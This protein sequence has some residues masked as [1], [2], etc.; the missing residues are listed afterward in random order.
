MPAASTG[1]TRVT[2]ASPQRRVDVV[3]PDAVPLAELLPE[4]LRRAGD[5]LA[6]VG[7]AHGGWLLHRA[8][9]TPLAPTGS[10]ADAAV[11]DG[12][13]L[14]LVPARQRWPELEYDDVVEEIAAGARRLGPV[15]SP[16]A[17]RA[18]ALAI[19]GVLAVAALV[20]PLREPAAGDPTVLLGVAVAILGAAVVAA[21]AYGEAVVGTVLGA[22]GLPFA[23]VGGVALVGAGS[24]AARL[25]GGAAGLLLWSCA[26]AV[27]VARGLRIFV[28]GATVGGLFGG[29]AL[30][31]LAGLD[32]RAAAVL[33][34]LAVLGVTIAPPAAVRLGRLP[35]P[36]VTLPDD[37]LDSVE[38]HT[39]TEA[40][41][42]HLRAAVARGDEVLTG[43]LTGCVVAAAGAAWAL[44]PTGTAGRILTTVAAL[45]LLMRARLF[46]TVR[47][48]VPLLAGGVALLLAVPVLGGWTP[49]RATAPLLAFGVVLV[50]LAGARYRRRTP[51]PYLGRVA[52]VV[53]TVCL[54]SVIPLAG[55]VL[56]LYTFMRGLSG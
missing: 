42:A 53:D 17:T 23:F 1:L 21:R 27:L 45:A 38:R 13:V 11:D 36:V 49:G 8:D 6:D 10:L 32:A 4:L 28:A 16:D 47:Q 18:A 19:A 31:A 48:R 40:D 44:V 50:A 30:L 55:A 12:T 3:L 33:T 34:V 39:R 35:L 29:A 5:G 20:A 9:G 26:S 52:D 46:V 51:S 15:W 56:E 25:L 37:T 22:Y 24:G 14:H 7:Q 41:R 43:L 54:V 2:V